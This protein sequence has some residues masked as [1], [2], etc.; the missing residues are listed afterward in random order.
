MY[1]RGY[2]Q[3]C[4][5]AHMT[6]YSKIHDTQRTNVLKLSQGTCTRRSYCSPTWT[7]HRDP[8]APARQTQRDCSALHLH[9][10]CVRR[11]RSRQSRERVPSAR[12]YADSATNLDRSRES[13][14]TLTKHLSRAIFRVAGAALSHAGCVAEHQSRAAPPS[15]HQC[16]PSPI[17]RNG[18]RHSLHRRMSQDPVH[19]QGRFRHQIGFVTR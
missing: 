15:S 7:M 13:L 16:E 17:P 19:G 1:I 8:H 6:S 10:T 14:A 9:E 11:N 18:R 2:G 3:R 4:H 5:E 12:R